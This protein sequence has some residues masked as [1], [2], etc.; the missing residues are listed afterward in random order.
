MNITGDLGIWTAAFFT[1]AIFSFLI[2]DNPIYKFAEHVFVGSSAGYYFVRGYNDTLVPKLFNEVAKVKTG[3]YSK[4]ILIIPAI[5][6]LMMLFKLSRK[7]SWVARYP[8]SFTIGIGTGLGITTVIQ[9]DIVTQLYGDTVKR[10]IIMLM[11]GHIDWLGSFFNIIFVVAVLSSLVYFFFSAE[12]KG[13]VGTTAR[14][15]I[16]FLM[17]CFGASFG[18]T[19]MARLSLLI[20][21]VSFLLGNFLGINI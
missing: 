7:L 8:L 17:V 10:P 3:D 11:N 20:N 2:K 21:R 4:L 9:S 12:H 14:I 1:L 5:L 19:V 15:G 18:F 6:G 16:W 13:V